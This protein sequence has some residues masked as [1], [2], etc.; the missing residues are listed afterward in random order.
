MKNVMQLLKM[1]NELTHDILYEF[2]NV[3]VTT[4]FRLSL[5][6]A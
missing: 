6:V 2:Y 3:M 1:S 5:K 4:T